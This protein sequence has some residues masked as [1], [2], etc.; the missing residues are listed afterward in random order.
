MLGNHAA[1]EAQ[2]GFSF[3]D[4]TTWKMYFVA[5]FRFT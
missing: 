1:R 4:H 5:W 2:R 3:P